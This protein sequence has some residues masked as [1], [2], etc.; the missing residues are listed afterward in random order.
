MR[1]RV[2]LGVFLAILIF[3]GY[4]ETISLAFRIFLE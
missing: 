1:V 3:R 4:L 2:I